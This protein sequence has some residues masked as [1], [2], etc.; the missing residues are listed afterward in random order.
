[1]GHQK[2]IGFIG[3]GEMGG[4]MAA[5]LARKGFQLAVFD[6]DKEPVNNLVALGASAVDSAEAIGQNADVIISMVKDSSQTDE[7]LFGQRGLWQGIRSGSLLVIGSTLDPKYCQQVEQKAREK[8][9]HVL[10]A[11]VL[12]NRVGAIAATLS[13]VVGGEEQ[14]LDA[15]RPVFEAMGQRVFYMGGV[16]TGQAMK[17]VINAI[18]IVNIVTTS[19]AVSVGLKAAIPLERMLEVM[20]VSSASSWVIENWDVLSGIIR[21]RGVRNFGKDLDLAVKFA[22]R[23]G[24]RLPFA[25]LASQADPSKLFPEKVQD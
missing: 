9:V 25:A 16:G 4:P 10:D 22:N 19:E 6:I 20:K 2:R 13:F 11:A 21:D 24:E 12:G 5:N 8:G 17:L 14:V 18:A 1:M 7:V 3:L 15:N 23:I